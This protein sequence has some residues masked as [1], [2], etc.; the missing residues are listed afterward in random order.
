MPVAKQNEKIIHYVYDHIFALLDFSD[1]VE[2]EIE[3]TVQDL[4]DIIFTRFSVRVENQAEELGKT[5]ELEKLFKSEDQEKM[6][7]F[8]H[9]NIPNFQEIILEEIDIVR[10]HFL[11]FLGHAEPQPQTV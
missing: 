7:D 10:A 8:I 4:F 1:V 6:K 11:E 2:E 5:K 9:K 3:K